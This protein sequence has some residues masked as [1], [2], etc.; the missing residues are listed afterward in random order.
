MSGKKF[1]RDEDE[2]EGSNNNNNMSER[3]RQA[4]EEIKRLDEIFR[5]WEIERGRKIIDFVKEKKESGV[6]K[7]SIMHGEIGLEER[8][9]FIF[10]YDDGHVRCYY[11]DTNTL[12]TLPS[13]YV[14]LRYF[15]PV[16]YTDGTILLINGLDR[17]TNVQVSPCEIFDGKTFDWVQSPLFYDDGTVKRCDFG[18]VTDSAAILLSNGLVLIAGGGPL[19]ETWRECFFYLPK[20]HIFVVSNAILGIPRK[21]AAMSLFGVGKKAIICGG[22]SRG[23][24]VSSTEIYD[25]DADSFSEGPQ[26]A[27]RRQGHTATLSRNNSVIVCGGQS[28]GISLRSTEIYN[29]SEN[30]FVKGPDMLDAR[31]HHS[32]TI[33]SD[34]RIL[35]CGGNAN[36]S[37]EIYDPKTTSFSYGPPFI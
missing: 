34:G 20:L 30:R 16:K 28:N 4:L 23:M 1:K 12:E 36:N 11:E 15:C 31:V 14:R 19:G 32:A 5:L 22:S 29:P 37:S 27:E 26:M 2:G 21:K 33:L 18:G 25:E 35:I 8:K 6:T 9:I 13:V 10:S 17:T 3:E 7:L 24:T